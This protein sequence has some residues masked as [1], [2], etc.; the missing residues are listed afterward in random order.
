MQ[1]SIAAKLEAM[2]A[3]EPPKIKQEEAASNPDWTRDELILAL[4]LYLKNR[5]NPP[6]KDSP[7]IHELSKLLNRLGQRLFTQGQR[8]DTFRN[9][10]GVYMKLMNFRHLDPQ[11]TSK[12]KTGLTRGAKTDQEVWTEFAHDE[13]HCWRVA[14]AII[15]SLDD[16]EI[17]STWLDPELDEGVQEAVE[18]R[19]LTR[20]H[21][22]RE[23]NR[24][25]VESKRRQ[26]LKS[27][28]RLVCEVC[29]FDF[30]IY[31]GERGKGFIECHH[32]KPLATLT[33]ERKTH[34][35]DL[36][37]L[38]A[39]CHRMIHRSRPWLSVLELR[40]LM[41]RLKHL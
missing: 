26:V 29:D 11:Y 14:Q 30:A 25:L 1:E 35:D 40:E 13:L 23:R 4:D 24:Q 3:G 9:E 39:N 32:T 38:C 37:L 31:Y 41:S 5:P 7:E 36:A 28:G 16:P 17:Q 15:A 12:G 8:A 2:V 6:G 10:N 33:E 27:R 20:K 19:M 34:V 18:G 21:L 22:A